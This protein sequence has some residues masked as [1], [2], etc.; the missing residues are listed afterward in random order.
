MGDRPIDLLQRSLTS[1]DFAGEGTQRRLLVHR[2]ARLESPKRRLE[3]LQELVG[4][5]VDDDEALRRAAGLARYCTSGP[6][7]PI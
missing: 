7:P 4:E 2:I 6:R 1:A 5:L 3:P